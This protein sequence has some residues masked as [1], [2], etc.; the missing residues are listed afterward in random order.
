MHS[1]NED[2]VFSQQLGFAELHKKLGKSRGKI[3]NK[4]ATFERLNSL[5]AIAEKEQMLK[6]AQE[7]I[8]SQYNLK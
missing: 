2:Y 7:T 6:Q 8:R 4:P 5:R 1:P 3:E